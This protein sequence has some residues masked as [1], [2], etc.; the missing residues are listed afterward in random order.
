M[1]IPASISAVLGIIGLFLIFNGS[2]KIRPDQVETK[3]DGKTI[4][5]Y[6][7]ADEGS[8]PRKIVGVFCIIGATLSGFAALGMTT[9]RKAGIEENAAPVPHTED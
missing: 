2:A 9:I 8:H 5:L 4:E 3:V 1:S 7:P 6:N